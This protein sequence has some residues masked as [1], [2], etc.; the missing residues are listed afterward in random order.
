MDIHT[1]QPGFSDLY[2]LFHMRVSED[3]A[4]YWIKNC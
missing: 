4:E 1:Y 3:Q 2:L